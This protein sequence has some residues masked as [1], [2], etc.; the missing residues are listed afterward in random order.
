MTHATF[1]NALAQWKRHEEAT[2]GRKHGMKLSGQSKK[3]LITRV[4][5]EGTCCIESEHD[6]DLAL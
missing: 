3:K 6:L 2:R 4:E 1:A 5:H